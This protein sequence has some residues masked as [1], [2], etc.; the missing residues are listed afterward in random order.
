MVAL[1]EF[2]TQIFRRGSRKASIV[3]L[4]EETSFHLKAA[5][6]VAE[7]G[8]EVSLKSRE[9]QKFFTV[10]KPYCCDIF[11]AELFFCRLA[12]HWEKA[13]LR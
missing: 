4:S 11:E 7:H 9:T 3:M 12:W 5:K 6:R 1:K 13:A 10:I 2:V 8:F